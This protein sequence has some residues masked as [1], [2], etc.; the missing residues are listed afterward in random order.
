MLPGVCWPL[1]L[2]VAVKR[3]GFG[4]S[5]WSVVSGVCAVAHQAKAAQ[6]LPTRAP[7]TAG[8]PLAAGLGAPRAGMDVER[9]LPAQAPGVAAPERRRR[10]HNT[11]MHY[12]FCGDRLTIGG[13]TCAACGLFSAAPARWS[14]SI[15]RPC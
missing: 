6:T 7:E 13:C 10:G 11:G 5:K 3:Q 8:L 1:R 14:C 4:A 15:G 2:S 12:S 9:G